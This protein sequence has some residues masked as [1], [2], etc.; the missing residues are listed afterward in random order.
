M[1]PV[2]MSTVERLLRRKSCWKTRLRF[3]HRDVISLPSCRRMRHTIILRRLQTG[4][5][6]RPR[7]SALLLECG[8]RG[9]AAESSTAFTESSTVPA[10]KPWSVESGIAE[11]QARIISVAVPGISIIVIIV[12]ARVGRLCAN[13]LWPVIG[14]GVLVSSIIGGTH[15]LEGDLAID[16]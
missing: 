5:A 12:R 7:D 8:V 4:S 14:I 6:I 10:S 9:L 1:T 3:R 11:I 16:C 15:G 2:R 13:V